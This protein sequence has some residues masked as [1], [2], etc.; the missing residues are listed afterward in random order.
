MEIILT[1]INAKWIHPSL[2]LRLLKANMGELE[3]NCKIIEFA[4][5]QPLKEKIE[6]ITAAKDMRILGISVSIWNHTATIELLQEL[7]NIWAASGKKPIVVLGG[8]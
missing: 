3:K 5:R 2:A 6:T 7:Q 8:P 1:T 4:L